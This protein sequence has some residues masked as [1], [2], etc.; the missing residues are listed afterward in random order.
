VK[1][2]FELVIVPNKVMKV[3]LVIAVIMSTPQEQ[4]TAVNVILGAPLLIPICAEN[5]PLFSR[6]FS[7]QWRKEDFTRLKVNDCSTYAPRATA[8]YCKTIVARKIGRLLRSFPYLSPEQ[9]LGAGFEL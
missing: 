2:L 8:P 3:A 5:S 7:C 4:E 9:T 1:Y 6:S